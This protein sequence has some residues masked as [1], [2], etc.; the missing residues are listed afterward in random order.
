MDKAT[1]DR[2]KAGK[3]K[4][5][6]VTRDMSPDVQ[7][8]DITNPTTSGALETI[9][10]T[11]PGRA[12]A[13]WTTLGGTENLLG[14]LVAPREKYSDTTELI[15][16]MASSA[17]PGAAAEK[18]G[19]AIL[20]R[21]APSALASLT[22]SAPIAARLLGGTAE[23]AVLGGVEGGFREGSEGILPGAGFGLAT[24]A[25]FEGGLGALNVFDRW[26]SKKFMARGFEPE[27]LSAIKEI[28]ERNGTEGFI[29]PS[30]VNTLGKTA[31]TIANRISTARPV[32]A[33]NWLRDYTDATNRMIDKVR[34]LFST[35]QGLKPTPSPT[36][37]GTAITSDMDGLWTRQFDEAE[38]DY[39]AF[40]KDLGDKPIPLGDFPDPNDPTKL[41]PGLTTLIRIG[42]ALEAEA[43]NS[44]NQGK[45]TSVVN[46]LEE[47]ITP[48]K[49]SSTDVIVTSPGPG[50]G[51]MLTQNRMVPQAGEVS[52]ES[53]AGD[54]GR[55]AHGLLPPDRFS[56][57]PKPPPGP[58]DPTSVS[59]TSYGSFLQQE[60][61]IPGA[62]NYIV[63]AAEQGEYP[64]DWSTLIS[65]TNLPTIKDVWDLIKG[66]DG[67]GLFPVRGTPKDQGYMGRV[68]L[69]AKAKELVRSGSDFG[70]P[71]PISGTLN[72]ADA[73]FS[74][75]KSLTEKTDELFEPVGYGDV[76]SKVAKG[77]TDPSTVPVTMTSTVSRLRA[78]REWLK[79]AGATPQQEAEFMGDLARWKINQLMNMA[80]GIEEGLVRAKGGDADIPR[81]INLNKYKEIF[82]P[83]GPYTKDY[84]DELLGA[85]PEIRQA[86]HDLDNWIQ[87]TTTGAQKLRPKFGSTLESGGGQN[88]QN[89]LSYTANAASKIWSWALGKTAADRFFS[90]MGTNPYFGNA[91]NL[92]SGPENVITT[93]RRGVATRDED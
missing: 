23:N 76:G 42:R 57:G 89:T 28:A 90:P 55:G 80:S 43:V 15:G 25:A 2:I 50:T 60:A 69:W 16:Q 30:M 7:L 24:G 85:N 84:M 20:G 44:P 37:L 67:K 72:A 35:R 6:G 8:E 31:Q 66:R 1:F 88:V 58:Y 19:M 63:R 64:L 93:L 4:S 71:Q 9:L 59:G 81:S 32:E 10:S 3:V 27:K 91:P 14:N 54:V 86:F 65:R 17:I 21:L 34:G 83:D 47:M 73:K 39:N 79:A 61:S 36:E 38:A 74:N 82:S 5:V 68:Q 48:R 92:R 41:L 78:T 26:A 33:G 87:F 45:I 22:K 49:V 46:A 51:P 13:D 52:A 62:P 11:R 53:F 70:L 75:A 56:A 40:V 77:G 29:I 12:L 18:A